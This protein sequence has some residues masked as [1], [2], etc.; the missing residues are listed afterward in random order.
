MQGPA[1]TVLMEYLKDEDEDTEST[2][3]WDNEL[4]IA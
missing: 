1:D 3:L 2:S 4:K